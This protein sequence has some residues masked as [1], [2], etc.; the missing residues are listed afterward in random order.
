MS[1]IRTLR[2]VTGHPLNRE[3]KLDS[4]I[5]FAKWQIGSR[6]VPGATVFDWINGSKFFVKPGETGL[7][8][9]V[10]AGLHEFSDM[11][12]LL[13]FLRSD[14]LFVDVGANV[15]SYTILAAAVVGARAIAFEPVPGTFE[16]LVDN[17]RLNHLDERVRCLNAA[18]SDRGGSVVLTN[19]MDTKNHVLAHDERAASTTTV[20]AVALDSVLEREF[21]ALLKIDVEGYELSVLDG[22]R[23]TLEKDALSAVIVE[24]NGSYDRYGHNE[25][26]IPQM[27]LDYGF[28]ACSYSPLNRTLGELDRDRADSGNTIFVRNRSLVDER[29]RTSPKVTV[30]GKCF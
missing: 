3:H 7:T 28:R 25:S 16:R 8:G 20:E 21:P 6:L 27:L 29:L 5:R 19:D 22:A 4:I 10:Y 12:F 26:S 30:H 14:D 1:L 18:V 24:S 13:H 23:H 15:G 17:M 11:G 9:N 2:F